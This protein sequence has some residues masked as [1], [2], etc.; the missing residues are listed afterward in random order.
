M[1]IK[2]GTWA[3]I[4]KAATA[5]NSRNQ[6]TESGLRHADSGRKPVCAR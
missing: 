2:T 3:R 6:F 1:N 5:H 4:T